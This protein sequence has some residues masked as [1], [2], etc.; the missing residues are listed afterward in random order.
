MAAFLAQD[1]KWPKA[2]RNSTCTCIRLCFHTALADVELP[3]VLYTTMQDTCW[4][5]ERQASCI[6][7]GTQGMET[8]L[9]SSCPVYEYMSTQ[10]RFT[11]E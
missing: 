9:N 7:C 3:E 8:T 6:R 10:L 5:S 4:Y 11:L 2:N 1:V